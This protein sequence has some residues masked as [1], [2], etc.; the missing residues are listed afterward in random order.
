[1][2]GSTL[3]HEPD[4]SRLRS[5]ATI[6]DIADLCTLELSALGTIDFQMI[7]DAANAE[8]VGGEPVFLDEEG[9]AAIFKVN[10]AGLRVV[11]SAIPNLGS[12]QSADLQSIRD[13][14]AQHGSNSI[15]E[16]ATF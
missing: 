11:L 12:V 9:G 14:V 10:P 8:W 3:I 13:F 7:V 1:M 6:D 16:L 5:L 15:Y 2:I 4:E